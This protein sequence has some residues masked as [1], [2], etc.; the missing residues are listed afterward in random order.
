VYYR[1]ILDHVERVNRDADRMRE[2]INAAMQVALAQVSIRQNEVVKR[3]AGWGGILAVPTMV[4]SLY[5]MN[6]EFMPELRWKW[7]Y[8][9]LMAGLIV[10]CVLLY[11]RLRQAGWL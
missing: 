2:M 4:F 3:L 5:G 11:R 6:F 8:P 1:D 10:G 9:F 7:S